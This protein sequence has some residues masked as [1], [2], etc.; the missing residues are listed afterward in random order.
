MVAVKVDTPR[1][2][3]VLVGH[4]TPP[5]EFPSEKVAEYIRLEQ[6]LGAGDAA[7]EEPFAVLD[8]E[9]R[10]LPRTRYNDPYWFHLNELALAIKRQSNLVD[11]IAA[12]NEF[13][14][15]TVQAAIQQAVG[16]RP[17]LI[18]VVPTMVVRGG[19]HS[20]EDI[21]RKV[22]EMA[23]KVRHIP[24]VYAWPFQRRA[25][26][27]FFLAH[28]TTHIETVREQVVRARLVMQDG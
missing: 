6:R 28:I 2:I 16:S 25:L 3:V 18:V 7:A 27:N 24:I 8:R 11:V 21:R 1:T 10:S 23:R 9:V 4:G 13:C 19:P 15:P 26:T 20:E 17:D 5:E 22:S 12:F 14:D